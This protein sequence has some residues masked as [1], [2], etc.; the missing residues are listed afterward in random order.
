MYA[1]A[2]GTTID[3]LALE[4]P[5]DR[6]SGMPGRP[7]RFENFTTQNEIQFYINSGKCLQT[8]KTKHKSFC[9]KM[10]LEGF[11]AREAV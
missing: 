5:C 6:P 2:L 4:V 8:L 1:C 3:E 10:F 7:L 11:K 9:F